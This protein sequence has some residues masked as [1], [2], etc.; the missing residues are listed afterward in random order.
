[1]NAKPSA[2]QDWDALAV[3]AMQAGDLMGAR[4]AYTE[5]ARQDRRNGQ[6]QFELASVLAALGEI[7]D[8]AV[9]LT[10]ALRLK[11]QHDEA[12]RRLSRLIARFVISEPGRLDPFGLKVALAYAGIDTQPI[13]EAALRH[14]AETLPDLKQA[15]AAD[16][17]GDASEAARKLLLNRTADVLK[18]DLLL[19]ALQGGT[20][21]EPR[22]ERLFTALRSVLL[23]ELAPSRFED[24]ALTALALAL[25]AQCWLNDHAWAESEPETQALA[26]FALDKTALFAG[27]LGA[28]RILLLNLLYRPLADV[29]SLDEIEACKAIRP[30][31]IRDAIV[32]EL[33]KRV[34]ERAAAADVPRLAPISDATSLRVAGQYE[35]SPYPRWKSLH[36]STPGSLKTTLSRF[37]EPSRLKVM[38]G[39]FDVL[40]A[41][42]GTGK[43]AL[44]ASSAYGPRAKLLATDLSAASLG[45]AAS[46]ARRLK[47]TNVEWLVADILDLDR[48]GRRF[49][50]IECVGV[51]HHMA[52]P[53]AGWR[54]LLE[55][56]KPDGLMC[57]GLYS[58][59]SRR[60]IAA[61][62]GEPGYP[63]P[64]CDDRAARAYRADL[65]ARP[66]GALGAE[67]R[68][69]SDFYALNEFRDLVLHE[70]EQHITLEDIAQ[71]L[72]ENDLVFRGFTLD[73]SALEA[74]SAMHP[75]GDMPGT[76]QQ[77]AEFE[78]ANPR[79]FD[80]MYRFWCERRIGA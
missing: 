53:W 40:I 14:L 72:A 36:V 34:D 15:L 62:R 33:E 73:P 43:H 11:P 5:A 52:D 50:I 57:I 2:R 21:I 68:V 64:G 10:Q 9:H 44:Q 78:R 31:P 28:A 18:S 74:F 47:I 42:A 60:N 29:L 55:C 13:A 65:F 61:L 41:G 7:N 24:R 75:A 71:F 80:G 16:Q 20:V 4:A 51:L 30:K 56:L 69:S 3:R 8:S 22:F 76:L 6:I 12:A 17:S 1:M 46:A 26:A 19:A 49:D 79:T 70:S 35:A 38:D 54:K 39:D 63:G 45:Y 66:E 25:L 59:V 27:D 23:K 37:F 32:A 58:A 48:A 77:W 67:L